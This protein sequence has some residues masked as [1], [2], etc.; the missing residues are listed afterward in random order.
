MTK[1]YCAQNKDRYSLRAEGH[2]TGSQEACSGVSA[3]TNALLLY[4]INEIDHVRVI[5]TMEEEAGHFCL[6]F[7]GDE[8]A[9]AAWKM[10]VMGLI[11]ISMAYP[12]QV[13]V[14]GV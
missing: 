9:G 10:A 7:S 12:E 2:A 1:I 13:A 6:R 5:H 3:I 4:A 14:T 11:S 8:T